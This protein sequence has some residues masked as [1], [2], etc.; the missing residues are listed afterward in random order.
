MSILPSRLR[1]ELDSLAVEQQAVVSELRSR[2]LDPSQDI[3]DISSLIDRSGDLHRRM[4][5]IVEALS[6]R[7]LRPD[8]RVAPSFKG[9]TSDPPIRD[10]VADVL[11]VVGVPQSARMVAELAM[12]L[13]ER[14]VPAA[15]LASIRRDEER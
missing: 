14:Q 7:E 9:L 5:R 4:N 11:H 15:R 6:R 2:V 12:A 8:G 3:R 1:A 10:T 13:F